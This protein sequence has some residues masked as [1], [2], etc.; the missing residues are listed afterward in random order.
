[1][2][3]SV[4]ALRHRISERS[5][6]TA[7]QPVSG[8][9]TGGPTTNPACGVTANDI[10]TLIPADSSYSVLFVNAITDDGIILG[11]ALNQ[12]GTLAPAALLV[13]NDDDVPNH[14]TANSAGPGTQTAQA[15]STRPIS[16]A[17]SSSLKL[18]P[19]NLRRLRPGI[20]R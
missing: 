15:A 12:D 19:K 6:R 5:G 17:I 7:R 11:S 13:P 4:R 14:D 9:L 18:L 1:M 16:P 3:R 20:A 8:D 2:K 10:S